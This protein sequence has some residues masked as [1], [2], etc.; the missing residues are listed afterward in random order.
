MVRTHQFVLARRYGSWEVVETAALK[1]AKA[2][3][4]RPNEEL[5]QRV[6]ERTNQLVRASEALREAQA[7]LAHVNR[8]TTM[9]ELAASIS[10]EV[11]QPIAAVVTNAGASL[12]WLAA[13]PPEMEEARRPSHVSSTT[14]IEPATS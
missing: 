6:V 7:E 9:G 5:E 3:I 1:R 11:M 13:Q 2:E 12:R 8:V 4:A 14:V 10:H